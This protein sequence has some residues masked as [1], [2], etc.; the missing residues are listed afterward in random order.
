MKNTSVYKRRSDNRT[1]VLAYEGN[2]LTIA[3]DHDTRSIKCLENKEYSIKHNKHSVSGQGGAAGIF[4]TLKEMIDMD[5]MTLYV[6]AVIDKLYPEY[7]A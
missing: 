6:D 7:K 3:H 1:F 5:F 4:K 2:T